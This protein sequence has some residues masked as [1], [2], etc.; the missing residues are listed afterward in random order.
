MVI[1]SDSLYGFPIYL[2]QDGRLSTEVGQAQT[3][4]IVDDKRL[5][6][7]PDCIKVDRVLGKDET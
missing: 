2:G 7:A 1:N 5:V 3:K 4:K 6:A